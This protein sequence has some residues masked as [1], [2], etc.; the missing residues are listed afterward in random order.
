MLLSLITC[1]ML[2]IGTPLGIRWYIFNATRPLQVALQPRAGI[3]TFHEK[4][5]GLPTLIDTVQDVLPQSRIT[6]AS[7][8]AEALLLF[9]FQEQPDTPVSALQLYG[10]TDITFIS[11]RTPRFDSSTIPHL[12]S[13]QVNAGKKLRISVGGGDRSA[14]LHLE[15]P[16]GDFTLGE[17]SYTLAVDAE[18]TEITVTR[19]QA[20]VTDP[21]KNESLVLTDF[22]STAL[23]AEGLGEILTT[24]GQND[25]L[26]NG[27]FDQEL[28][29][30]WEAYTRAKEFVNE[31][32]G[33]VHRTGN[34]RKIIVFERNGVG[35]IETGIT[36]VINE[37]ISW[38]KSLRVT[39]NLKVDQQSI[40]ICGAPA[41][42]CPVMIRIT[43][44]DSKGDLHEW[45]QGFYAVEGSGYSDVCTICEGRPQHILVPRAAWYT[46]TSPDLLPLFLERGIELSGI[47]SVDVYASGHS[48]LSSVDEIAVLV[49]E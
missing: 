34:T 32:E 17:G 38:A 30:Y 18:R 25:L 1:I 28:S 11:A 4:R 40:P 37:N 8:D 41:T 29:P 43:Y 14:T 9:Y 31:S 45:L 3:V 36:Q 44:A 42:E 13:L 10:E 15:T 19:G 16:K 23:T 46:Y 47:A 2:A 21:L 6:L 12:I 33:S 5:R 35:H 39:I 27:N 24:D 20:H 49:E 26:R 7:D 22:Q 48:F